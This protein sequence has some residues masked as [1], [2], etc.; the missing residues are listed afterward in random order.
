MAFPLQQWLQKRASILHY[1]YIACFVLSRNISGPCI[2]VFSDSEQLT[3]A[4]GRKN[5]TTNG[6]IKIHDG[7]VAEN[8]SMC[9]KARS[10]D[11]HKLLE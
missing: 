5:D 2:K 11:C 6:N 8:G 7:K 3:V 10:L 1:T 4:H 9:I